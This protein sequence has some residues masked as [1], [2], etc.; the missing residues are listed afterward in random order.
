MLVPMRWLTERTTLEDAER[1]LNIANKEP[2]PAACDEEWLAF[3]RRVREGDSIWKY[4]NSG[5]SW[6]GGSGRAGYC[7]VRHG[8]VIASILTEMN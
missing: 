5:A 8:G 7:I 4:S 3:K 1:E 2:N 6:S